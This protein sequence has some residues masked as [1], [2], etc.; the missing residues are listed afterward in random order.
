MVPKL[1]AKPNTRSRVRRAP[2][3]FSELD[4]TPS[5][6]D[7]KQHPP[8][9]DGKENLPPSQADAG[10]FSLDGDPFLDETQDITNT[11]SFTWSDGASTNITRR[12]TP[13]PQDEFVTDE[14]W[15]FNNEDEEAVEQLLSQDPKNRNLPDTVPLKEPSLTPGPQID[16]S[17]TASTVH[18]SSPFLTSDAKKDIWDFSDSQSSGG[19]PPSAA[20][21]ADQTEG[22]ASDLR[23]IP[24]DD[25]YDATPKKNAAAPAQTKMAVES[26]ATKSMTV[27]VTQDHST[28]AVKHSKLE[29]VSQPSLRASAKNKRPRQKAKEPIQFDP[30]TQEIIDVPASKKKNPPP[31]RSI[32]G[33]LQESA[34]ELS[35]PFVSTKKKPRKQAPKPKQPKP[36]Q[37]KSKQPKPK[38]PKPKQPKAKPATKRKPKVEVAQHDSPSINLWESSPVQAESAKAAPDLPPVH[39]ENEA[40]EYQ[41]VCAEDISDSKKQNELLHQPPLVTNEASSEPEPVI[42]R[43]KP[44]R[45]QQTSLAINKAN[46]ELEKPS[47]KRVQT[48]RRQQTSLAINEASSEPEPPV[49]RARP[50]TRQQTS[51]A[52]NEASDELEKPSI[53]RVQPKRRQQ[54]SLV[55]NETNDE[56]EPPIERAQPKRR[57]LSRHFSVSEKGSPVLIM[58]EAGPARI[59]PDPFMEGPSPVQHPSFLRTNS[60]DRLYGEQ[61]DNTVESIEDNR[62]SRWFP[63][64]D[65]RPPHPTHNSNGERNIREDIRKSF[66]QDI[67]PLQGLQDR[68]PDET[69]GQSQVHKQIGLTVKQLMAHLE[70]KKSA[71][72]NIVEAYHAGGIASVAYMQQQCLHDCRNVV[73]AIRKHGALFGNKLQAVKNAIKTRKQARMRMTGSLD[74]LLK[75]RN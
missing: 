45:R 41:I 52:I 38:Q 35:S 24:M 9:K 11:A 69:A 46:V 4:V 8:S 25:I 10:D 48:K 72:S 7:E 68:R 66:L 57:K 32:V 44:K 28:T 73:T 56:P 26:K 62:P 14:L 2:T 71:A 36:K 59:V 61:S 74:E 39:D 60:G 21:S 30:I 65:E 15:D 42:K 23:S 33:A 70:G 50:K 49:E 13:A 29:T 37:P 19:S 17:E 67:G 31:K 3:I 53:K 58:K 12:S 43:A 34:K 18:R 75:S 5:R 64:L 1:R 20:K 6:P 51:P 47:I 27:T 22:L 16:F 40:M 55:T 63:R 54:T